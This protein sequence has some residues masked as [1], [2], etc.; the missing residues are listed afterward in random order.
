MVGVE[1][2]VRDNMLEGTA[3]SLECL[4]GSMGQYGAC[5]GAATQPKDVEGVSGTKAYQEAGESI[6]TSCI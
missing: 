1:A 2:G 6:I 4:D 5:P 3:T